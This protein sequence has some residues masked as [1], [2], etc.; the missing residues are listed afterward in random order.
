MRI[1]IDAETATR[2]QRRMMYI[3]G[4][5]R[6]HIKW[7]TTYSGIVGFCCSSSVHK[8][9]APRSNMDQHTPGVLYADGGR[10]VGDDDEASTKKDEY[11]DTT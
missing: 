6:H 11:M 2:H 1:K 8:K 10:H 7:Y 9:P 3:F 5:R 4:Q